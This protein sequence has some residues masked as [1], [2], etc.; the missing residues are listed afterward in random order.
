[1]YVNKLFFKQ[2][3]INKSHD[4]NNLDSKLFVEPTE[5]F[6]KNFIW[7]LGFTWKQYK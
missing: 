2:M 1:M 7:F 4:A 3:E 6:I 5:E